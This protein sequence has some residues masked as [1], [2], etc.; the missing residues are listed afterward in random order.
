[1]VARR[2]NVD[3]VLREFERII[4]GRVM[5]LKTLIEIDAR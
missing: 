1:V 2:I 5:G 3:E 4:N